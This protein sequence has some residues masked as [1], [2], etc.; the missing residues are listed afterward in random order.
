MLFYKYR[1]YDLEEK[2]SKEELK[3]WSSC[4][5]SVVSEL[6]LLSLIFFHL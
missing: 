2:N 6:E 4:R 5:G 3:Y 1:D